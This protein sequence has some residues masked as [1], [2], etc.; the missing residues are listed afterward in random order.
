MQRFVKIS[1]KIIF[2]MLCY[3]G[4]RQTGSDTY[5]LPTKFA[6]VLIFS[7]INRLFLFIDLWSSYVIDTSSD[8]LNDCFFAS[9]SVEHLLFSIG[10]SASIHASC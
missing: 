4:N 3:H 5:D 2:V 10:K 7:Y 6:A 1:H 9:S 8:A